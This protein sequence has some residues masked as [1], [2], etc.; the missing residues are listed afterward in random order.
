[1][2]CF[3]ESHRV[4][5]YKGSGGA[6]PEFCG[7]LQKRSCRDVVCL[8]VF[9]CMLGG[10]GYGT[11]LAF[12]LGDP[13]RLIYGVDSWGNVCGQRNGRIEGVSRSGEDCSDRRNLFFYDKS[14]FVNY[15]PGS[16][17]SVDTVAV[18]VKS[19]PTKSQTNVAD[20]QTF[21]NDTGTS[22]CWYDIP[23][24]SFFDG[25]SNGLDKCPNLPIEAQESF[26]FRCIPKSFNQPFEILTGAINDILNKIDPNFTEKCVSD[27]Q[28]TWQEICYLSA[29]ALGELP[30]Y[31]YYELKGDSSQEEERNWLIGSIVATVVM[32][33]VI[34][35]LLVMRK[36][37]GLVVQ[38]FKEAGHV[39]SSVPFL[40]L[41]PLWIFRWYH[42]IASVWILQFILACERIVMAGA[43]AIWYFQRDSGMPVFPILLSIRRLVRYHLGS[44]AFGSFIITLLV[45]VNWIL[46]FI[47]K[48]VKN[49]TG[50]VGDFLMKCLR[51]CFWCFENAIRFINSNAY[52]EIAIIGEGFC[53]SAQRALKIIVSNSLRLAAINSIGDFTLFLGKVGTVAVVAVVGIEILATRSDV[54][55]PWLPISLS[56]IIAFIIA[57]CLIGVYELC[58]DTIFICFCEDCERND[59]VEKP[60]YMS[61]GLLK[62]VTG[63]HS[64]K[65]IESGLLSIVYLV[66]LLILLLSQ[67][68]PGV[69]FSIAFRNCLCA[70]VTSLF[71]AANCLASVTSQSSLVA[72]PSVLAVNNCPYERRNLQMMIPC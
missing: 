36:R 41:L 44:A 9:V 17:V 10:T 51:C 12:Y 6:A 70:S 18:C 48:R 38:L 46:G 58:I 67:E 22:L 8:L 52:I 31:H 57:S 34:L 32:V 64:A 40:L 30:R 49:S 54:I 27:L 69:L 11:Y 23:R 37:I 53:S 25:N 24:D 14:I 68:V 16:H 43:V 5:P 2:G 4:A 55:Y 59:G 72:I 20:L 42:L 63:A 65:N 29:T 1:M 28:K 45:V 15:I 61:T 56:C 3:G 26:L 39:V 66:E 33:I 60:Y 47:H 71:L 50:S 13:D 7:P 35:V 21:F 62:F 19:C